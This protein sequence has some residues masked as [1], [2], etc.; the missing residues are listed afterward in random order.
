MVW[1]VDKCSVYKYSKKNI[2]APANFLKIW[3]VPFENII[4]RLDPLHIGMSRPLRDKQYNPHVVI[5]VIKF[6]ILSVSSIPRAL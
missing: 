5:V 3:S 6:N 2:D 1:Y 4:P